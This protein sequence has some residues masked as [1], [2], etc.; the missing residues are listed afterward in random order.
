MEPEI[1]RRMGLT[2]AEF[3]KV[4][5]ILGREP[6]YVELGMFAVMW[7]EHCGYKSSRSVL[8]LFPTKAPWV[9]QGP[10]EN[11]GI[12]DIG[13]GQAVVFKIESHNHPSAIE[14]FQG[15]ATGVGG[16][17]RDI[18]AMGA[19]PIA[20]LN[21]LRFGPLDDSRTRY[22]MGGVVG[23]IAFYGNCLGLP[24]VAGEVYFEPSYAC[25]PLVNVMAVGLIEQK[26]IR[27]GTA[28]GVGNAV[29]LIGARTGRDGIHGATFASE[30]LSE[31]SEERRPSVQVGDPFREKLLIEACLEIINEDLIIGMQD[32]GAAG[33]T[34]SSC[35]MAARAGTGM[36]IDIALVPRREEGMTPYEVMLSESQERML[37]VP[38]KGAEERIRAICRRW[39]LE[40]VIIGR[41]TGDGLM[42]IMENGRVVAEV[43]AK[44]LTDQ[45]P[46][47]ERERRRPAYLDEVRQRDLSRLPEPEDYGRVLL[48]LLAAPN[49][50][51]KEWVYRQ[52]DYMVR[53]DTVAGPGGDAAILR[54]KGTSKGLALTVDGNGRYCYLDPERGGAIAVAEAARNLACVGARPLAITDCLNF[55][56]P[57]KPEVA[58]QFYQA[59]SG[60]S[61]ACEV[62]RTPVTGGNVSFYNETESGAIYPTPVVGM[63]G[64][65]PDI[66][67]RC[68]IGFRREG[69]LL[70]LMG[71]TYPEIGGS[72]YLATFHGL[73]AGEPPA[74]DLER[75]KAVQALVR[76][77]I[78]AGLATAAHDCAEGGLAVALAE[79]ALAGGL[80][81]E[82]ELASDLRP[83]FLLFSESQSRILLAVAPEAR[84]R[85]LDLAREKGVRASVIGRCGGHSL[86]VRINGRTLFNLSLEEM[87]KQWRE[88]I[89]VLMAR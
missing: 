37:L 63:V 69:D 33:I 57:E 65:L 76:E 60:M 71:E 6:N 70:I 75:E 66:E 4:K 10:G 56:N 74:L 3:E 38:K 21:S 9:L 11:A 72:E 46:V 29:M 39:G 12:V 52:Y 53:T 28:A 25:N 80:G 45:C 68:G 30:E 87:G 82:V 16:I 32:M 23:G 36:E 55:G 61:R 7:S 50:A 48:G 34:S 43:P 62:L 47:Y 26:N 86:V 5:A 19:R 2:D 24:T 54:V 88:S 78:A 35:E 77:V 64:L 41:V 89:P 44:A 58:W 51:S 73:V 13:D 59:V 83:D 81:A 27:R 49:L 85:V 79:S 42:R 8:K 31:A 20:V 40:A 1:Y 18:F 22:L 17:V 67:K 15:A 84:D 14:P